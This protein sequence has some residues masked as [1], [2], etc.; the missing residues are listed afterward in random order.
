M[1]GREYCKQSGETEKK[2][3]YYLLLEHKAFWGVC[4]EPE[5]RNLAFR[6]WVMTS[7]II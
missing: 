4:M 3:N 5:M 2:N 6:I 7:V 1:Q